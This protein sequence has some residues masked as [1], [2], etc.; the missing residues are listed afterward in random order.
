VPYIPAKGR[1]STAPRI[2]L[3]KVVAVYRKTRETMTLEEALLEVWRSTMVE[4]APAVEL[5]G[6]AFPV[7]TTPKK[8]LREV[9]FVFHRRNCA[10]CS[11]PGDRFPMGA[12]HA[13]RAQGHA[14]PFRRP[15]CR[16]R[17]GRQGDTIWRKPEQPKARQNE[18][19]VNFAHPIAL[20]NLV[21]K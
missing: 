13:G 20:G 15:L 14:I 2:R 10:V 19:E 11:R 21:P 7:R 6:Q 1:G 18:T 5:E 17:G 12:T 16:Q 8:C 4:D 3:A 9:D